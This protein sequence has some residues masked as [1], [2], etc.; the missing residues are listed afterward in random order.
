MARADTGG[1]RAS[2]GVTPGA[3]PERLSRRGY[4]KELE[5]L[6]IELEPDGDGC[7]LTFTHVL[8]TREQAARDAAGWHVCLD[9]LQARLGGSA[10]DAPDGR[11]SSEWRA[12]YAEYQDR[13]LPTGAPI[14]S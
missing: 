7:R 1:N 5:R 3:E 14:P 4:E 9:R 13:G 10:P 2:R 11:P 6:Q 8:S 12:H